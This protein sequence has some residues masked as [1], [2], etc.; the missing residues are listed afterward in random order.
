M[1]RLVNKVGKVFYKYSFITHM[2]NA[3][4]AVGMVALAPFLG[5]MT[6]QSYAMLT[7][8]LAC[9]GIIG[10]FISQQVDDYEEDLDKAEQV[11]RDKKVSRNVT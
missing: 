6:I 7:G 1:P 2:L 11:R 9:L 8:G 5:Y 10:S 3:V 4:S